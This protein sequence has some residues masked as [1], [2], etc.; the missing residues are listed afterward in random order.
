MSDSRKLLAAFAFAGLI[1][2]IRGH[3]N[4]L[5]EIEVDVS[6]H[7][8]VIA[9]HARL[10]VPVPARL[11]FAVLTDYDHMRQFLPSLTESRIVERSP[12]R[13][14]VAQSGGVPFGPV[15]VPFNYVRRV[16]LQPPYKLVSQV[17]SGSVKKANVTTT[18]VE[19]NGQTLVTYDSEATGIWTPF[20]IGQWAIAKH[21]RRQL[22][23]MRNEMLRRQETS[24]DIKR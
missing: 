2:P 10:A 21:V 11:A 1:L 7:D 4:A 8:E 6:R 18:L 13:L 5:P 9:V 16:D 15:S 17:V 24:R 20:G 23:S 14:L 19:A 22:D 3:A 12:T